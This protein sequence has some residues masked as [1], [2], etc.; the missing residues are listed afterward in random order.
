M[1]GTPFVRNAN[2]SGTLDVELSCTPQKITK[3][4]WLFGDSYTYPF[5]DRTWTKWLCE[6]NN[7]KYSW[8]ENAQ[9][10]TSSTTANT[11]L[12]S[13]MATAAKPK[14]IVWALGMNDGSD[15]D[16]D[17]PNSSWLTAVRNLISICEQH[18]ITPILVTIPNVPTINHEGKNKWIKESGYRYIDLAKAVGATTYVSGESTWYGDGTDYDYLSSDRVH[19]TA[20]G[21]R[22]MASQVLQD[23][24]EIICEN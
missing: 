11:N 5:V 7:N 9:P 4:V 14:F 19:A 3:S 23:F 16:E 12:T 10:G 15:A 24:P 20:Y 2:S 21:G 18:T 22:A 1:G 17:T 13:L 8:L 6:W